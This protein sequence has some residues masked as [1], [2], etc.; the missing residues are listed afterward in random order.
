MMRFAVNGLLLLAAGA[1]GAQT[2]SLLVRFGVTDTEDR[3]WDGSVTVTGGEILNVRNWRPRA[4]DVVEKNSWKLAA[5]RAPNFQFRA[6]EKER[7]G[8]PA[9][10]MNVPGIVIDVKAT[11]GTRLN[12]ATR[13]GNFDVRPAQ[14][15]ATFLNGAVV[16]EPAPLA[17]KLS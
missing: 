16:V 10:I 4:Q 3:V 17:Q 8:A 2:T 1:A 6:W 15:A 13:Q 14:G 9:V 5:R 11:S 12:F 7:L